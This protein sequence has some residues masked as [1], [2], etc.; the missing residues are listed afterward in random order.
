MLGKNLNKKFWLIHI[1][2]IAGIIIIISLGTYIFLNKFTRHNKDLMVP[3]FA[4]LSIEEAQR[5]ATENDLRLEISDSVYIKRLPRGIITRQNPIE[6]SKVKKNRR[7]FLTINSIKAKE[8]KMPNLVGFSLRQA[9]TEINSNGLV[10][11]RLIYQED[12]ATNIVL[13]PQ[14][15]GENIEPDTMIESESIIDLVLGLN[16]NINSRT[17]IP[18][19]RGYKI[20]TA[21]DIITDNSLNIWSLKYDGTVKT[22]KDSI[23]A[24]VYDQ[25]PSPSDSIS[26]NLGD[27]VTLYLSL[28]ESKIVVEEEPEEELEENEEI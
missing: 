15:K 12:E 14:Y 26:Y 28:D 23:N 8:S 19:I 17:Y 6:G 4:S 5:I 18:N 20:N 10:V 11:G 3:D 9:K 22:Y 2:I 7:I 13:S 25:Y 27:A 21:K 16:K 1:G 24:I